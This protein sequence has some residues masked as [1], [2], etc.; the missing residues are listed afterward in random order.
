MQ[1]S[2]SKNKKRSGTRK[3]IKGFNGRY[4]LKYAYIIGVTVIILVVG[5]F[6]YKAYNYFIYKKKY[7]FSKK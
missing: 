2:K 5:F 1:L 7:L 4:F 6:G 3:K